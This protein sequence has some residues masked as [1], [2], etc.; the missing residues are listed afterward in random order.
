VVAVGVLVRP[1]D[2]VPGDPE[3][4]VCSV[5]C[6][7]HLDELL[8]SGGVERQDVEALEVAARPRLVFDSIRSP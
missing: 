4:G 1:V 3:R 2:L 7:L 8:G 5:P 6:R